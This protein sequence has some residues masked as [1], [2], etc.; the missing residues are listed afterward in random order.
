MAIITLHVGGHPAPFDAEAEHGPEH[1]DG[2]VVWNNR[3][4]NSWNKIDQ[5]GQ[6]KTLPPAKPEERKQTNSFIL[7]LTTGGSSV[8]FNK[9]SLPHLSA[10]YP[11]AKLPTRKPTLRLDWNKST[12]QPSEHTKLNWKIKKVKKVKETR[13]WERSSFIFSPQRQTT[14]CLHCDTPNHPEKQ[15]HKT[16]H[17]LLLKGIS[18][19]IHFFGC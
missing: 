13:S 3:H 18:C 2:H 11:K 17:S 8:V 16:L 4:R 5:I 12:N 15:K 6:E 7:N 1:Q 19:K 9:L 14:S 10:K